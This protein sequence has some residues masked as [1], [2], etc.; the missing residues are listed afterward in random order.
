MFTNT[1][2]FP[3]VSENPVGGSDGE[4]PEAAGAREGA[5]RHEESPGGP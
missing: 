5:Q 3:P 1:L 2:P 4:S